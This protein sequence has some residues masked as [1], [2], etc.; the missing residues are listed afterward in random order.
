MA[1][2]SGGHG[3]GLY[4]ES[5]GA[6]VNTRKLGNSRTKQGRGKCFG[7]PTFINL[8]SFCLFF[9]PPGPAGPAAPWGGG[10]VEGESVEGESVTDRELTCALFHP[11][12]GFHAR[13]P[14]DL[15]QL[16]PEGGNVVLDLVHIVLRHALIL[17]LPLLL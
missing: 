2:L 1:D 13:R 8:L 5:L 15:Q 9:F 12:L 17:G 4:V 6:R 11:Y 7:G 10:S 14:H 3:G 16:K